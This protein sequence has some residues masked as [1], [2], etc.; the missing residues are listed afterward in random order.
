MKKKWVVKRT[1]WPY[2]DGWGVYCPSTKTVLSTGLSREDA[3][4]EC[5]KLNKLGEVS[6]GRTDAVDANQ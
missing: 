6:N 4:K 3:E 2:E 1:I 5:E